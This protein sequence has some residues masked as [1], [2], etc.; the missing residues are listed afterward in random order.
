[1]TANQHPIDLLIR[2]LIASG[3]R[4]T[5]EEIVPVNRQYRGLTYQGR[6]LGN[7]EH[8]L[9]MHLTVRVVGDQQWVAGTTEDEYVS[10]LRAAVW[11]PLARLLIYRRHGGAIAAVLTPNF[12]PLYRRGIR[13]EEFIFVV[14][15]ADRS[16]IVSGYQASGIEAISI[17]GDARWLV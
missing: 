6:T 10:D 15:S 11:D 5:Q 13:P 8:S 7:R 2:E 1:V 17:P 14:Y 4:A 16:R 9:F 3:R 12:L